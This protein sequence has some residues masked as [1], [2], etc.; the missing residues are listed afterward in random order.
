MD[1]IYTLDIDANFDLTIKRFQ[2][3]LKENEQIVNTVTAGNKLIITTR[4]AVSKAG[5]KNLL[6]EELGPKKYGALS[7][8]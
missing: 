2:E 8:K 1:R 3:Q 5:I 4:E 6:L 7:D